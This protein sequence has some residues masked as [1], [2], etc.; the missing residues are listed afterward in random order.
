MPP[1]DYESA[2][3]SEQLGLPAVIAGLVSDLDELRAG[4][5]SVNDAIARSMLAKQIFN[6]VRIYLNGAKLLSDGARPASAIEAGTAKT[7]GL[8]PKDESAVPKGDAQ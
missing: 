4:K 1:R 6:G 7:E 3:V 5:I 2:P 8:G